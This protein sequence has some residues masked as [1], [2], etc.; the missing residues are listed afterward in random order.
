[1]SLARTL[2]TLNIESYRQLRL[3]DENDNDNICRL[4]G[5]LLQTSDPA[6]QGPV[7]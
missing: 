5:D 3:Y 2:E 4:L 6:P 1:M 7:Q